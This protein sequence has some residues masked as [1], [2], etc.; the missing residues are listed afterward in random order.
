MTSF[1]EFRERLLGI[2]LELAPRPEGETEHAVPEPAVDPTMGPNAAPIPG[3]GVG[4][5]PGPSAAA[6]P[7]PDRAA[8][9]Y[10]GIAFTRPPKPEMGDLALPAFPIAK[11]LGQPPPVVAAR[12]ADAVREELE[13]TGG[14]LASLEVPVTRV[15]AAGPYVNVAL[16]PAAM[17][18]LVTSAISERGRLYGNA[19]HPTGQTVMVEYSS[20]NT[21]KPLHL[22]HIRNGLLGMGISNLLEAAGDRVIRV[23]L[24]ND[25]GIHI[26]KSMLAYQR[27]GATA[28][29]RETPASTGEKGDHFVGRYY[30][31]FYTRQKEEREAH[32]SAQGVDLTRFSKDTLKGIADAEERKTREAHA[33]R[34]E[35]AFMEASELQAALGA[36]LRRWE[37][38]DPEVLDLW[39]T[40]NGW[41]YEGFRTSY[42]RLGFR[43]DKWY[44]ESETWQAGKAEVERGL[45]AG[46]FYRNADGSTWAR[47]EPLGLQDKVV[48]RADGTAVY[49]T[50]DIST[51]IR[52]FEDYR[53]DRS[54]Y[55]VAAEQDVHFRNLFAILGLLGHDLAGRCA[56][57][58]YAMVNLARGMG[59]LKSREGKA[60]D[61]DYLLDDLHAMAKVKIVEAGHAETPDAID[62]TAE[63]I[64]QGALKLYLLQVSPERTIVFDPEQTIAFAGDTGPAVQ[65][66]HARIHGIVRKGLAAGRLAEG[67]FEPHRE[68]AAP[69]QG[70]ANPT[71]ADPAGTAAATGPT[72]VTG[73]A[74]DASVRFLR[75]DRADAGLL[76]EPEEREV[77]RLLAEFPDTVMAA[78]RQLSPAPVANALLDL[79]KAYARMYHQHEVLKAEAP[80]LRARVQL[81]LCTA[82]VLR[83][84]LRLLTIEAPERM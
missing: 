72:G 9:L 1:Q 62:T 17:A 33:E 25:R 64:G 65:Y 21:N 69:G 13:R 3:P 83:N 68:M 27:W 71:G 28:T 66:S 30:V 79:T 22:G 2:L 78:A 54:L 52:K 44:F 76:V 24:V 20:P 55:V 29:G 16:D 18:R 53:M 56:H 15:L 4:S 8:D 41:V 59:K 19:S 48:L 70:G 60:V 11:R 35:K 82:Q 46:V 77:L 39:R 14:R 10:P 5:S 40:M 80:L 63:Q 37:A 6:G 38:G 81:A 75:C 34:F 47:L 51:T 42:D 58:S 12:W 43:F 73:R 84:G 67:D 26:C 36:M 74:S 49:I 32:A 50:Q 23:S 31:L 7:G 61:A 57:V 45:A